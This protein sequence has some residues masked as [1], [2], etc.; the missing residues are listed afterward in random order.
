[1]SAPFVAMSG[2]AVFPEHWVQWQ[3]SSGGVRGRASRRASVD[4]DPA[5]SA[6]APPQP[7]LLTSI[8]LSDDD[9]GDVSL[10]MCSEFAN[11]SFD[12]QAKKDTIDKVCGIVKKELVVAQDTLVNGDTKFADLGADSLDT[13]LCVLQKKFRVILT[14]PCANYVF[15]NMDYAAQLSYRIMLNC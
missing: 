15:H 6:Q 12:V 5:V 3:Q 14:I 10:K 1:M 13:I 8:C 7:G 4:L 2:S 9:G 11:P